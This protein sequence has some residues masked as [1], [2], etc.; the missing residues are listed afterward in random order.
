MIRRSTFLAALI[1]TVTVLSAGLFL[2]GC[3][4]DS[5]DDGGS[6]IGIRP[7]S[8]TIPAGISTNILL[9]VSG[10]NPPYLWAVNNALGSIV[11]AGDTAIYT[12]AGGAGQNFVTVTDSDLQSVTATINQI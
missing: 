5:D 8:V 9:T 4:D 6:V 12:S 11:E 2:A 1:F 7:M 3:E 10:G